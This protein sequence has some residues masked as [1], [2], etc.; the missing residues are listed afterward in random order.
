MLYSIAIFFF[1][2]PWSASSVPYM[3][4]GLVQEAHRAYPETGPA[5]FHQSAEGLLHEG[6]NEDSPEIHPVCF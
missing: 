3:P 4:E 2:D 1:K 5:Q 6:E